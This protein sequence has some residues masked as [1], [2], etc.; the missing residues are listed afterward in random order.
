MPAAL[1]LI[2]FADW[3]PAGGLRMVN[4]QHHWKA[5]SLHMHRLIR[6]AV[7]FLLVWAVSAC[8]STALYIKQTEQSCASAQ[9]DWCLHCLLQIWKNFSTVCIRQLRLHGI[10]LDEVYLVINM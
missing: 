8:T 9:V 5:F 3:E 7:V 2:F 10:C 4:K 1:S 6:S